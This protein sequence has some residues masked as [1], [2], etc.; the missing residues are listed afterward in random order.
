MITFFASGVM[1]MPVWSKILITADRHRVWGSFVLLSTAMGFITL[2]LPRGPEAFIPVVLLAV[3]RGFF[4]TPQNFLPGAVLS[5]VID[6]DTMKSGSSKAGNLFAVQMLLIKITM[7]ISGALAFFILDVSGFRIGQPAT[8]MGDLGLITA[9]LG[10]PFLMHLAMAA[11]CWN[12]PINRER[13]KI[14]QKRLERRALRAKRD[15]LAAAA[16]AG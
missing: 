13:H 1:F 8:P 10:F 15:E 16:V 4:G 6:Y 7:A 11:L 5:D 9:Y 3:V 2:L 14:I 12:F